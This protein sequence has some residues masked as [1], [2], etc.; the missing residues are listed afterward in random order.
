[1]AWKLKGESPLLCHHA[2]VAELLHM[3]K[4]RQASHHLHGTEPLQGL[5][6][7]VPKVLM[8]LPC[9]VVPTSSKIEWLCHLNVEDVES[10]CAS[11]YLG[12]KALMAIL[13]V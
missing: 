13:D 10:V 6:L 3:V 4:A 8:P 5:E 2:D 9:L 1:L 7:K 12:K 11:G